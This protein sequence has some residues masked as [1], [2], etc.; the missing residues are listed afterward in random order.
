MIKFEPESVNK[1][2]IGLLIF[3]LIGC[4]PMSI[5]PELWQIFPAGLC[6][7][8]NSGTK[9]FRII[10]FL[11]FSAIAFIYT[12]KNVTTF[13]IS[14]SILLFIVIINIG[15]CHKLLHKL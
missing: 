1:L 11:Y 13:R 2:F 4:F 10:W 8:F 5:N 9:D 7:I 3:I 14:F 12:R 6:E 15:G